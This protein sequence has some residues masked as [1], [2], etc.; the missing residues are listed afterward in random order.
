MEEKNGQDE[1]DEQDGQ[2]SLIQDR[3]IPVRSSIP[4]ILFILSDLFLLSD[5]SLRTSA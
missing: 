3:L 1:Q 2:R 4:Y 5:L